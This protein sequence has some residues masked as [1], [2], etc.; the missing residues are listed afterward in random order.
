[1]DP[2]VASGVV[3]LSLVELEIRVVDASLASKFGSCTSVV[4]GSTDEE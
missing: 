1:V 4:I 3:S 2:F